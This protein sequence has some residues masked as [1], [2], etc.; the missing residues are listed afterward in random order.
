MKLFN[1]F[2]K[3]IKKRSEI[4]PSSISF[5]TVL[6]VYPASRSHVKRPYFVMVTH[7]CDLFFETMLLNP[8]KSEH[9]HRFVYGDES[10]DYHKNR[11]TIINK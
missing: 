7:S 6:K 1:I 5:G 9:T 4:N 2:K 10:W 3:Q 8:F 11:F